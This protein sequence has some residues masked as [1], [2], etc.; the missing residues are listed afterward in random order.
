MQAFCV[1]AVHE[2]EKVSACIDNHI[3]TGC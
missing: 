3:L 2:R 1:Q